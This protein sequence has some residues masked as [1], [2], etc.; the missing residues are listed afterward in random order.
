VLLLAHG[1]SAQESSRPE[2]PAQPIQSQ[3]W[4]PL[5][6]APVDQAG[7]GSR[8]YVLPMEDSSVTGTGSN[9]LS[10]HGVAANYFYRE[11]TAGFLVT[12]RYE[13]HT[14]ALDYRRG[15]KIARLPRFEVGG[16]VQLH[17]SG[18]GMLNGL[19]EGIESAWASVTGHPSAKNE[20]RT[21]PSLLPPQGTLIDRNGASVYQDVGTGAGL[22]DV[23]VVAKFALADGDPA[24]G[25]TRV[26]ARA[27][28]NVAHA[29]RFSEG[30]FFGAGLS[31]GKKLSEHIAFHGDVRA[32]RL[33][34]DISVWNLPLKDWSYGFSAGTEVRLALNSSLMVQMGGSSTPYQLTGTRGF[35][36]AYGDLTFGLG[37]RFNTGS[38]QV[39]AHFYMRENLNLP[40]RIRWN[41]DPDLAIGLKA[42]IR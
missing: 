23:Y 8:G 19:I 25:A 31:L 37:H 42:T 17:Q 30:H 18:G 1:A 39:I 29:S 34:D 16:H 28:L 41:T 2:V 27:G 14:F 13:T 7:T 36:T 40:F 15:F 22:G 21:T 12:Q 20:L 24:S 6:P 26:S 4:V 5:G 35:D 11:Q 9:Q 10:F 33:L 32:T 38:R 3:R